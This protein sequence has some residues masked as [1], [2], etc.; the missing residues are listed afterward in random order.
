[1]GRNWLGSLRQELGQQIVWEPQ[2]G[3]RLASGHAATD[4]AGAATGLGRTC[5]LG[6]QLVWD[7]HAG[8][9]SNWSGTHME[10]GAVIGLGRTC[11]LGQ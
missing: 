11:R 1:M 4:K 7:A 2:A 6:Q 5:R 8:P 10:A 3:F 9:D